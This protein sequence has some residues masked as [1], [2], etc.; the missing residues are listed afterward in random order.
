MKFNLR[1]ASNARVGVEP[2]VIERINRLKLLTA[3]VRAGRLEPN[4]AGRWS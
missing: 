4:Q 3:E 2:C 1:D